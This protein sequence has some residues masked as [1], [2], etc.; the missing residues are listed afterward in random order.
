MSWRIHLQNR[1]GRHDLTLPAR[2]ITVIFGESGCGKTTLLRALAGL[3]PS[4]GE[5]YLNDRCWQNEQQSLSCLQRKLAMV[6]QEPRLLP[7]KT[8]AANILLGQTP[9]SLIPDAIIS[10]LGLDLLLQQRADTLSGGEQQRT[11]LAR[12]LSKPAQALLLDEPLT[13]LDRT[14]RLTTIELLKQAA[15]TKPV[16]VVTHHLDEL[17]ALADHLVLMDKTTSIHGSLDALLNH[18][19]L[20]KQRGHEFSILSGQTANTSGSEPMQRVDLGHGIHLRFTTPCFNPAQKVVR[21]AV[22]ARDVSIS[23]TK[24]C[25]SSILNI[26]PATIKHITPAHDGAHKIELT[27]AG[28]RLRALISEHSVNTLELNAGKDVFVQIKGTIRLS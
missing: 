14:R 6:F 28:Q 3:D 24:A 17:L 23:L 19:L 12:A 13:G 22:D 4:T 9:N 21:I 8:V 15:Q 5:I 25:D 20:T 18:P 27:L 16:L 11:A 7:H 1:R 2:G 10:S 26:L